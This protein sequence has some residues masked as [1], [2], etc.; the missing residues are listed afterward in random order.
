MLHRNSLFGREVCAPLSFSR[1]ELDVHIYWHF[2]DRKWAKSGAGREKFQT[3]CLLEKVQIGPLLFESP[4]L[5]HP[6]RVLNSRGIPTLD[7][8]DLIQAGTLGPGYLVE[9]LV[10]TQPS[11]VADVPGSSY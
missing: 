2:S 9:T 4:P 10:S 3:P 8:L 7:T 1:L 11:L 5:P 6:Y